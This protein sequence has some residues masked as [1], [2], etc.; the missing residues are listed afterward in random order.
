MIVSKGITVILIRSLNLDP[1]LGDTFPLV[2]SR[3]E[4][5]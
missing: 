1:V 5:L 4:V 2:V 3:I